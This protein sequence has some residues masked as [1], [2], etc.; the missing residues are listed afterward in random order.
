MNRQSWLV[1]GPLRTSQDVEVQVESGVLNGL[2]SRWSPSVFSN[3]GQKSS[4]I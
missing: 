3:S 4:N 2:G 1:T